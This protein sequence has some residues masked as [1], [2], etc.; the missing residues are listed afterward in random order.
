MHAMH[1]YHLIDDHKLN[2]LDIRD[3]LSKTSIKHKRHGTNGKMRDDQWADIVC[4]IQSGK[5]F[6]MF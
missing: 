5:N 4:M 1:R 6:A 3:N 2:F